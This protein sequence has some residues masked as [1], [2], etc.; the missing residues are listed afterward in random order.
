M[1]RRSFLGAGPGVARR[2]RSLGALALVGLVAPACSATPAVP[3]ASSVTGSGTAAGSAV[4]KG[5]E[6]HFPPPCALTQSLTYRS[7]GTGTYTAT[8]GTERAT[9]TGPV[10]LTLQKTSR[11]AYTGP[12]GTHGYS[13]TCANAPGT[14]F[15]ATATTTGA[16]SSGSVSCTYTGTLSRVN[17]KLGNGT[18]VA[19][20]I[21]HGTCTVKQGTLV[22]SGAP[23][24]EVRTIR[25]ILNSCTGGPAPNFSCRD[26]TTFTVTKA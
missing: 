18:D 10:Q 14:P 20:A 15:D 25:Y 24:T 16:S 22:V 17:P 4:A 23:T 5:H 6:A 3:S 12:L 8:M 13:P 2:A 26:R 9:Y 19:T 7:T 11:P 21:L 1:D